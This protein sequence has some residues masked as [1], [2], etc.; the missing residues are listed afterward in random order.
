MQRIP[1]DQAHVYALDGTLDPALRVAA[2]EPFAVE[3]DD[4][5]SGLLTSGELA[6]TLENLPYARFSPARANPVG[7]P[8]Y[9]EGVAARGRIRV[10]IDEIA[11]A[12]TGIWYNRPPI[13]PL[14]DSREW[15]EG[16][17]AYS[18]VIR[19]ED[20]EAA[21]GRLRWPL[22]PM[23]GTLACAPEWE[24]HSTTA[25]QGP[26]GGNLDVGDYQAGAAV[27]LTSYH[28]GGLLFVGDV[29]G[30]QG[31]GEWSSVADESRAEVVLRAS[32]GARRPASGSSHRHPGPDRRTRDRATTRGCG[33]G[34]DHASA[35]AGSSTSSASP[36]AR[37]TWRSAS[38]PSSA[39]ACTR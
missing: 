38:T 6:P 21:V 36:A 22:V 26:F 14:R 39:S 2:G 5:S 11:V 1:R 10:E 25:G 13:S 31:D 19:H 37:P 20:G 17:E 23:I 7:G 27:F 16:G 34:G 35:A 18:E 8:V 12:D 29:H 28:E 15:P 24:V 30:C 9:V 33:T 4:A 3:T 32:P